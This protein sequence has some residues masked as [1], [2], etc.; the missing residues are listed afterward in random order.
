MFQ[1]R[2][3]ILIDTFSL[4]LSFDV[5]INNKKPALH[6]RGFFILSKLLLFLP[7]IFHILNLLLIFHHHFIT[8]LELA[9]GF[10]FG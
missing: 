1:K 4:T 9:F 2:L 8:F 5:C 6:Q 10:C 7:L 3:Q